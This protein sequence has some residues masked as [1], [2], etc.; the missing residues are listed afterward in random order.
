MFR[1]A[2]V[3]RSIMNSWAAEEGMF[4]TITFEGLA[5]G[6]S[7]FLNYLYITR[8]LYRKHCTLGMLIF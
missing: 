3:L 8:Y 4:V 1:G 2:E 7:G 5:L 6:Y